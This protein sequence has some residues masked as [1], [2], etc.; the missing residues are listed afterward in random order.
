M[1][2]SRL[3]LLGQQSE[4]PWIDISRIREPHLQVTGLQAGRIAVRI[5]HIDQLVEREICSDGLHALGDGDWIQLCGFE[6]QRSLV[7]E[8]LTSKV[9]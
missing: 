1:A 2:S 4:G 3:A 7:C 6:T 8:V 5:R 9:A